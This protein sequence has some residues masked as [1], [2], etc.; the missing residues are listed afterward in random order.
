VR[1]T[2]AL[3][4]N[5][6][7]VLLSTAFGVYGTKKPRSTFGVPHGLDQSIHVLMAAGRPL[8]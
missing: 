3:L 1:G 8:L 2:F 7:A 5:K 4:K 6:K